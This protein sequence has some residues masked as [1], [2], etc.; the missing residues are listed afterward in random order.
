MATRA[1]KPRTRSPTA[2]GLFDSPIAQ[3]E[4]GLATVAGH[5]RARSLLATQIREGRLPHAFLFVGPRGVGKRTTALALVAQFFCDHGSGCA[6]CASCVKLRRGVFLSLILIRPAEGKWAISIDQIK[7]LQHD[8]AFHPPDARGRFCL[9]LG[10][11][12]M[13]AD[14]QDAFLKTLE[15]PPPGNHLLLTTDRLEGVVPTIRS[16][17][18]RLSFLPLEDA[19]MEEFAR[20]AGWQ[21][22]APISVAMGCPGLLQELLDPELPLLRKAL[23]RLLAAPRG[24]DDYA[25]MAA[26]LQL[27][28]TKK[29]E[30]AHSRERARLLLR[31]LRSL[32][33][34]L[35]LLHRSGGRNSLAHDMIRNRDLLETLQE[36]AQDALWEYPGDWLRAFASSR[37]CID[38]NIDPAAALL[39]VVGHASRETVRS[40]D[41]LQ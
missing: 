25:R 40:G 35:L 31:L 34:D 6:Q 2:P 1:T 13:T 5:E 23:A 32:A 38:L 24:C 26:L 4:I 10:A 18:Q 33:R 8:L 36:C 3:G 14:A 12:R 39:Q 19:Q 30:A 7:E 27:G 11:D 9:I 16:R 21:N 22:E 28:D 37:R 41:L 29:R 17:C 15:E 20:R